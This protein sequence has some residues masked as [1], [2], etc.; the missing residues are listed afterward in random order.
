MGFL[1]DQLRLTMCVVNNNSHIMAVTV[2]YFFVK[3]IHVL[4]LLL[5]GYWNP[6]DDQYI[7][8]AEKHKNNTRTTGFPPHKT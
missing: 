5:F 4:L 6:I 8:K 2:L 3:L 1:L 7:E